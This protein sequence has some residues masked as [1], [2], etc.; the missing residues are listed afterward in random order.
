MDQKGGQACYDG[1]ISFFFR[2]EFSWASFD[3][4][5]ELC[6]IDHSPEIKDIQQYSPVVLVHVAERC[7]L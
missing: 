7:G 1:W 6:N 5:Q 4:M 3:V 2:N